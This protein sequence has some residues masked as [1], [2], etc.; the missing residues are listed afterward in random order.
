M[1]I[2]DFKNLKKRSSKIKDFYSCVLGLSVENIKIK[3]HVKMKFILW[4]YFWKA[5]WMTA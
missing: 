1:R 2:R 3:K 4:R 5:K